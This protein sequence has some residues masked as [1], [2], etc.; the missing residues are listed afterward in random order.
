[1]CACWQAV[2]HQGHAFVPDAYARQEPSAV[3]AVLKAWSQALQGLH[4]AHRTQAALVDII[5]TRAASG[6]EAQV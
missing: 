6:S 3:P 1:M 4:Q 5:N 2:Y